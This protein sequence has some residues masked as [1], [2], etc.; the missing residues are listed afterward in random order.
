MLYLHDKILVIII[1]INNFLGPFV[2]FALSVVHRTILHFSVL[3]STI[4][5]SSALC[6]TFGNTQ[7][8]D[9]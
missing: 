9:L 7:C 6:S 2:F 4:L 1:K 5:H 8:F 3:H